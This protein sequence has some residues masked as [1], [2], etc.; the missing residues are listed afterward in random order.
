MTKKI[1]LWASLILMFLYIV[2]FFLVQ[3]YGCDESKLFFCQDSFI[4]I[5]HVV[6]IFP[7]IFLFSL[8]TY[9]MRNEIFRAWTKFTYVWLPL[10][11][12]LVFI[13]PEYQ[14]SWLP[15]YEKSFVSFVLSSLYVLI[16]T[17]L[18]VAKHFSLKKSATQNFPQNQK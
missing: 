14:N 9:K 11:L 2:M 4:W 18:I 7:V 8:I 12:I 10:T 13:A 3:K 16:S 17:I 15:I 6:T 1:V 5:V